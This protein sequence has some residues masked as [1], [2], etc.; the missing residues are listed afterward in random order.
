MLG[1]GWVEAHHQW[2]ETG[3]IFTYNELCKH[4]IEVVIPLEETKAIPSHSPTNLPPLPEF[5]KIGT[6]SD[7]AKEMQNATLEEE[8]EEFRAKIDAE[9]EKRQDEGVLDHLSEM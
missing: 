3:H 8:E 4:L 9:I 2:S 5:Q 7:L 1:L 6:I